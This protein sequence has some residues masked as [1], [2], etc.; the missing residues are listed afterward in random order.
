MNAIRT[1][2]KLAWRNLFRNKRRTFIAGSA[3]GI[4]L[5]SLIFTDAL[6]KGME[7]N[8]IRS[9]TSSF[10]GEGQIHHVDYRETS[11]V[12]LTVNDLDAIVSRLRTDPIV[13]H[14]TLRA[15]SFGMITSPAN[16]SSVSLIGVDPS[17]EPNLSQIDDAI[18][19]GSYFE[20]DN[21]RDILIGSKLAEILE[22]ELGDRV[23]M[24]VAQ[25]HTGDLSQEMFRISGI[26][27]FNVPEMDRGM[28]IIRLHGAQ[29]M[30]GIG[31]DVHE[32]AMTFT[33]EGLGQ[34]KDHPF[35]KDYS[36]NDDEAVGWTILLPQMEVVFE[37]SQFSMFFVAFF[38]FAVV[39]L[40]IIN[41]LFMSLHERMFEF[42]VLRA[43]G[44]R[45][46]AMALLILLEAASLAIVSTILGTIIGF[47]ASFIFS[48]VGIDYTGIEFVG[49]TFREL[50]YPIM[51]IRQFIMYPFYVFVFTVV[52][53]LYP[54]LYAARMK[55]ADAMRKSM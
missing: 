34:E 41:T 50:L 45:P 43:V 19:E 9:A 18:V 17:T 11:E 38:L 25:A 51:E 28:A 27:H 5:A 20:G 12:E 26:Y 39:T 6:M 22:V 31:T 1:Y 49:V 8:M 44:T 40:G 23:V 13:E 53:G 30:L 4:G 52:V 15:F 24:T 7:T 46:S 14:F 48:K 10:L 3:I 29:R 54:A 2:V 21:E 47:I 32:I 42:G 35:W 33:E 37:M 36:T 55:P 16:V